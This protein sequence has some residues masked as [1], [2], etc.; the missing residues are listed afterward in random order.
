MRQTDH[1]H[2]FDPETDRAVR[3]ADPLARGERRLMLAVLEDALRTVLSARVG[4]S[5]NAW[6]QEE[7]RWFTS[8]DRSHPFA[9]EV[10]CDVLDLDAS[11]LRRRLRA[12][13]RRNRPYRTDRVQYRAAQP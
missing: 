11:W 9:F 12:D 7:L 5:S 13:A 2:H 4:R 3:H 8:E 1:A 6:P 10:I